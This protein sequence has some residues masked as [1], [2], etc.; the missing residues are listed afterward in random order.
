MTISEDELNELMKE[1][2]ADIEKYTTLSS[3]GRNLLTRLPKEVVEELKLKKGDKVRWTVKS[4]TKEL[5][6][7]VINVNDI[8]KTS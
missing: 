3:D 5:K 2:N 1:P 4:Q 8:K 6:V 7:E